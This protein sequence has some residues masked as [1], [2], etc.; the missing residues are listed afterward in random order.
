M[1]FKKRTRLLTWVCILALIPLMQSCSESSEPEDTD[2]G[3]GGGASQDGPNWNEPI[4]EPNYATF[5][6]GYSVDNRDSATNQAFHQIS[7]QYFLW[8]TENVGTEAAPE[9]RF[10]T[11]FND[12]SIHPDAEEPKSHTLGGIVQAGSNSILIDDNGRAVYTTMMINDIYRDFVQKNNLYTAEGMETVDPNLDFPKGS[13]SLKAAWKI[14]GDDD[15]MTGYYTKEAEL[16]TVVDVDGQLTTSDNLPNSEDHETIT[17]KVALVGFHIAVVVKGHPEFLW[18]TFENNNN[19]PSLI[20]NAIS[21]DQDMTFFDKGSSKAQCNRSNAGALQVNADQTL[22]LIGSTTPLTTEV[23]RIHEFGGGKESNTRNID[24]INTVVQTAQAGSIWSNYHEVG[25]VWF[26]SDE[27][28]GMIHPDWSPTVTD[29]II[30]GS[31]TLSNAVIET[32]TQDDF[33]ANSCFACHNTSQIDLSS[34]SSL[35]GSN[36]L[37]SHILLQNYLN[38]IKASDEIVVRTDRKK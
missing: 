37:T 17:E 22:S 34:G 10:E 12:A 33:D 9:L 24:S 38:E 30:T 1:N 21:P 19:A 31:L 20:N 15:D 11:L 7:W 16:Y 6:Q 27:S 25:A 2:D 23:L 4:T 3:Y 36:V 35:Q 5:P 18:I 32:F 8:L 28:M 26:D 14:V 29:T 13:M